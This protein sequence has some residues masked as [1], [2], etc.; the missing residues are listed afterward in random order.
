[1]PEQA[2]KIADG[3]CTSIE[4]TS[5]AA[6]SDGGETRYGP[7]LGIEFVGVI[8]ITGEMTIIINLVVMRRISF[9]IEKS[10]LVF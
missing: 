1:V 10:E 5:A 7:A 3:H 2:D 4:S 8:K 6:P 9:P